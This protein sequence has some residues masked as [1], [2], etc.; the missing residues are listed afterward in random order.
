MLPILLFLE[1]PGTEFSGIYGLAAEA[2]GWS[3]LIVVFSAFFL[4]HLDVDHPFVS[5][6]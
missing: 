6:L 2:E 4:Y 1:E 3:I 5:Y